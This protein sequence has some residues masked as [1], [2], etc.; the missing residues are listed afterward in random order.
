VFRWMIAMALLASAPANAA[1]PSA[2]VTILEGRATVIRG[3]SQFDAAEGMRL[4]SDDLLRTD[5]DTFLR[6]EYEDRAVIELGPETQLQLNHPAARK[7]S[8]HPALYLLEG[9]LK[10]D[11]GPTA[12]AA[13]AAF[14][15][16]GIDVVD[17]AGVVVMRGGSAAQQLFAEQGSARWVDRNPHG[18]GSLSLKQGDFVVAGPDKPA[19]LNPR[20]TA[21]FTAA[22]PPPYRDTLPYRYEKFRDHPVLPKGPV[23]FSY[24]DVEPWLNA[25]ATVRRQ[26]VMLWRRKADDPAFRASLD[27]DLQ[28]HP[29][30]DP[31]LHPEKYEPSPP[32]VPP[33]GTGPAAASQTGV[34]AATPVSQDH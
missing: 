29:E 33:G 25:E 14:A 27:H 23:P 1:K 34:P 30:W 22:L 6:V 31:L 12:G 28:K 24:A 11:S 8:N 26:F 32:N 5:K 3:L 10:V 2:L 15:S 20:P 4:L 7:K 18:A 9:W 19:K 17:I 21:D 13:K 16:V